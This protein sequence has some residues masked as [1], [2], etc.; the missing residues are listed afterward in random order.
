[1]KKGWREKS[2]RRLRK[3]KMNKNN[4]KE[5]VNVCWWKLIVAIGMF[6]LAFVTMI[7]VF[8]KIS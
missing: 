5:V 6:L 8:N 2:K 1:M 4:P 7:I 3:I